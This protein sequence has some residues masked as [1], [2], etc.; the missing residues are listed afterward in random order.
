MLPLL[1]TPVVM[2]LLVQCCVDTAEWHYEQVEYK[3]KCIHLLSMYRVMYVVY[4][5]DIHTS[6]FATLCVIPTAELG[7]YLLHF[8]T[9][10]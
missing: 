4:R 8:T 3:V 1:V 7:K 6:G 10:C 5:R 2:L 9:C